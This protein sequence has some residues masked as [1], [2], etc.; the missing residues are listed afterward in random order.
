[1]EHRVTIIEVVPSLLRIL[2]DDRYRDSLATVRHLVVGS[3]LFPAALLRV[4]RGQTAAAVYNSYG[5]T[6]ATID[7]TVWDASG[8]EMGA[9]VPTGP[10]IPTT[11]R[12]VPDEQMRL[13]PV[14]GRG[15]L[16]IGG[17]G[18]ARGYVGSPDVTAER[19][20]PTPFGTRP[21]DRLYRTGD[22]VRR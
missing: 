22:L 14:G 10:P 4:V 6:E 19:F 5:P 1:R 18:L 9:S 16:Y 2:C 15:E 20:M 17:H 7:C 12:Y 8:D 3:E 11:E 13:V 21:G